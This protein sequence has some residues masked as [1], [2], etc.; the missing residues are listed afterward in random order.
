VRD[1]RAPGREDLPAT[2]TEDASLRRRSV[3][4]AA[5]SGDVIDHRWTARRLH[6]IRSDHLWAGLAPID[7]QVTGCR[8]GDR[9][10]A[11]L[12]VGRLHHLAGGADEDKGKRWEL[13]RVELE[14]SKCNTALP[15]GCLIRTFTDVVGG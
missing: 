13:T 12:G 11:G 6:K 10:M 2:K 8:L 14:R 4:R 7:D 1:N 15:A 9:Q 3:H 5:W